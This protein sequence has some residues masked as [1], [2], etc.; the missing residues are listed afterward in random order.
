MRK[1][2]R[3]FLRFRAGIYMT[4]NKLTVGVAVDARPLR[5]AVI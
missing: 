2:K 1:L 3:I 4:Y 5:C